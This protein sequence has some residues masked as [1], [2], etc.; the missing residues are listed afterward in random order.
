MQRTRKIQE[1]IVS[2]PAVGNISLMNR[3]FSDPEFLPIPERI[4]RDNE[5]TLL[6]DLEYGTHVARWYIRL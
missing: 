2:L 3:K 1:Q 6:S 4:R 5:G